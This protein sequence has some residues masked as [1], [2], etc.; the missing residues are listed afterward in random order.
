M[1]ELVGPDGHVVTV[2]ID[3]DITGQARTYLD[4]AGYPRT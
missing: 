1:A 3:A 4:R 2:D